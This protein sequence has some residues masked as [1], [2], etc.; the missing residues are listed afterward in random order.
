MHVG[1][2]GAGVSG[3][4]TGLLLQREGH[5][6]TIFE[7][8]NRVGGRIYTYRFTPQA[9]LAD[10]YFEAGAMRIPRSS[11]HSK[12][13]DFIRYLNTHGSAEQKVEL[14]PYILDHENNRSFFQGRKGMLQDPH[15]AAEAQ[16]PAAYQHKSPQQLL[17]E[18]VIPWLSLLRQDFEAGFEKLL[19]YD[20]YSFRSYLRSVIGWPHEV[21]EFVELFCSQ[22]NQYDLGFT[23]IIMQNLD[24][25]TKDW[26]TVRD[27]MSRI[28]QCAA[29]IIGSKNIRLNACVD[30]IAYLND[31]RVQL[32]ARGLHSERY[33]AAF[34]TVVV[35]TPPS[36][37][38][39]IVDR[40]QWSFM[41]EQAIR[42]IHY[43]PLYKIGLHFRTRFWE[44]SRVN[45]CFG[46]QSTTDLRFRWIVFPSN[47]MGGNGSG[48]LLL[49]CWM[50]DASKWARLSRPERVNLCLHDLNKYYADDAEVDIY[51]Q[52]IEAFDMMWVTE[53]CGGDAMFLPGQFSRF[54]EIA[55]KREGQIFFAG[56]HLSKHHTWIAGAIDSALHTTAEILDRPLDGKKKSRMQQAGLKPDST[57]AAL[58]REFLTPD[59][60]QFKNTTAISSRRFKACVI[61]KNM[62]IQYVEMF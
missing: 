46:G 24:F 17:G 19:Q 1:I 3:L 12:V 45:P 34:D 47:D 36:A 56:E 58:G 25:D 48:V 13:F 52:F 32:S 31:G 4:Y 22:T 26:A 15:W 61:P 16:L 6:V 27:G 7:A 49:Y 53:S 51:Q 33:T 60:K 2:V 29:S 37:L 40:P 42:G 38:Y 21:I 59:E 62:N 8:A 54:H 50:G 43:E 39:S 23:E 18:V 10:P 14:I 57:L 5:K 35:A 9:K 20:E 11:L 55:R 28:P 44:Q 41:K 30:H